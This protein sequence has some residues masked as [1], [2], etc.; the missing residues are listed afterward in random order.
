M[1]KYK[2]NITSISSNEIIK[3]EELLIPLTAFVNIVDYLENFDKNAGKLKDKNE[4]EI[5]E[6]YYK[7]LYHSMVY[8]KKK[9][10][11]DYVQIVKISHN[12][13]FWMELFLQTDPI[14]FEIIKA[15]VKE[16]IVK[17]P[18]VEAKLKSLLKKFPGYNNLSEEK[19]NIIAKDILK[20]ISLI[21]SFIKI[22]IGS[23]QN[24]K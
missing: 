13:P 16:V 18:I 11:G 3:P 22:D 12:S 23:E 9:N 21:L 7:N 17:S 1:K 15:L 5:S 10:D 14:V 19:Q 24:N 2:V 6:D 20:I 8:V 4:K